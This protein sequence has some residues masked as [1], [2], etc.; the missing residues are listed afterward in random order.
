MGGMAA[1]AAPWAALVAAA[2]INERD[3]R[4]HGRRSES[5]STYAGDLLSGA[6]AGQDMQAHGDKIG[7]PVGKATNFAGKLTEKGLAPWKLKG[8]D[9][10]PW[11]WF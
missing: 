1:A 9:F 10:K 5:D 2:A 11:E 4:K 6:V 7:G 8:K 3:A